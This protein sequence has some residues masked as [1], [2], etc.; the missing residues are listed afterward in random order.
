VRKFSIFFQPFQ[1]PSASFPRGFAA[2]AHVST[3]FVP[4]SRA[5]VLATA[6]PRAALARPRVDSQRCKRTTTRVALSSRGLPGPPVRSQHSADC[7]LAG[8][9]LVRARVVTIG[10]RVT[11]AELA[12]RMEKRRIPIAYARIDRAG[13][14]ALYTSPRCD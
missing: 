14:G 5:L 8:R 9:I 10:S 12:V 6:G 11:Q 1:R 2:V 3:G 4:T 7:M 13:N